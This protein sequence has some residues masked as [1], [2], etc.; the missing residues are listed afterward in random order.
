MDK[1]EKIAVLES[2]VQA[3]LVDSI[4]EERDIP[5]VMRSY[6]DSAYDGIFQT[7]AGWGQIEAP[8][9]FRDEILTAIEDIKRQAS[10]EAGRQTS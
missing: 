6:H 3:E 9:S 7:H 1:F 4:L 8:L 10:S 5:H 2:E